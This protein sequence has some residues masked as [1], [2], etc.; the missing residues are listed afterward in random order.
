M[1]YEIINTLRSKSTIKVVGNTATLIPLTGLSANPSVE[2]VQ[3]ASITHIVT[4]TDGRWDIYRGDSTSGV[5]VCSL[6][7]TS[8]LQLNQ[9]DIVIANSATSN[10]YVTNSGTGGTLILQVSKS[11]TYDP[12][13]GM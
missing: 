1:P 11:A 3:T 5:L 7:G 6:F 12:A 2:T 9:N 8:D 4:S 10:I 13:L